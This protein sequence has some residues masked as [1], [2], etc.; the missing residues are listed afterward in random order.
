MNDFIQMS[1]GASASTTLDS[2]LHYVFSMFPVVKEL[3]NLYQPT[4]GRRPN[5]SI[6]EVVADLDKTILQAILEVTYETGPGARDKLFT[7]FNLFRNRTTTHRSLIYAIF[8][9]I[10]THHEKSKVRAAVAAIIQDYALAPSDTAVQALL[11]AC[12][13]GHT[14]HLMLRSSLLTVE[15]LPAIQRLKLTTTMST[16]KFDYV[17]SQWLS[18]WKCMCNF[19]CQHDFSKPTISRLDEYLLDREFWTTSLGGL[20]LTPTKWHQRPR[21]IVSCTELISVVLI[22][23]NLRSLNNEAALLF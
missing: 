11:A 16:Q 20:T 1:D 18:L 12:S 3:T 2:M 14:C 22:L 19:I 8:C 7:A 17:T 23:L 21:N 9:Y 6:A 5:T 15:Q 13:K 10:W 4:T